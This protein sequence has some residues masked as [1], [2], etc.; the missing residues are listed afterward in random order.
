[1]VS[2]IVCTNRHLSDITEMLSLLC[3]SALSASVSHEVIVVINRTD[4][5]NKESCTFLRPQFPHLK[6][7]HQPLIGKSN[8]L[9]MAIASSSYDYLLFTDDDCYVTDNWVSSYL[10]FFERE[11]LVVSGTVLLD[12]RIKK[13][14]MESLHLACLAEIPLIDLPHTIVGANWAVRRELL[15]RIGKFDPNLGP[16]SVCG[17]GE[18]TLIG[19]KLLRITGKFDVNESETVVHRPDMSR[20]TRKNWLNHIRRV[21]IS[22]YYIDHMQVPTKRSISIHTCL[23]FCKFL[24]AVISRSVHRGCSPITARELTSYHRYITSRMSH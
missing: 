22:Q 12:K 6:V 1:M 18:D 4:F 20:I 2:I 15:V 16:G 21:A 10:Q 24:F 23:L 5:T 17:L 13:S 14:W 11:A 19:N 7:L 8:A 9:N 3:Q